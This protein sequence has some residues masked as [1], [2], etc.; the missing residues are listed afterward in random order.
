MKK[1]ICTTATILVLSWGTIGAASP[2]ILHSGSLHKDTVLIGDS[3]K[4]TT[5][6]ND[7]DFEGHFTGVTLGFNWY[8]QPGFKTSFSGDESFLDQNIGK[9]LSFGI[10][11]FQYE[12]GLQKN[13]N[14]LGLVTGA[15]WSVHNYRF[16][17][18][19]QLVKDANGN[20]TGLVRDGKFSKN[21]LTVS[22]INIPLLFE[23]QFPSKKCDNRW[24]VDLGGYLSFKIGSHT[25]MVPSGSGSTEKRR[26][27]ININPVQ[28]GA[29]IQFGTEDVKLFATYSL[30][31]LFDKTRA[32]E[33]FPVQVGVSI[34]TF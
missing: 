30:S 24:F 3:I 31:P 11:L 9:S 4:M 20:T 21:K 32:P 19:L 22:Y 23:I 12:I 18:D 8:V 1:Q 15:G 2:T 17:H 28:Y 33:V 7:N 10:N 16:N 13:N 5:K 6:V 14:A 26:R 25:K 34:F 29:M 27:D